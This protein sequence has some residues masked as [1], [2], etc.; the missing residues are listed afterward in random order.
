MEPGH[1]QSRCCFLSLPSRYFGGGDENASGRNPD[2]SRKSERGHTGAPTGSLA[3][4]TAAL[5]CTVV[6]QPE[7]ALSGADP[8]PLPRTSG[9][10]FPLPGPAVSPYSRPAEFDFHRRFSRC[11][12]GSALE[13]GVPNCGAGL[14]RVRQA[15]ISRGTMRLPLMTLIRAATRI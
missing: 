9:R 10:A 13:E 7:D 1:R 11:R 2:G 4:D 5:A 15:D 14:V 8:V 12:A 3:G 6:I